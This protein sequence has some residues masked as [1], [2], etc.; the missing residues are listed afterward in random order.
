MPVLLQA[1]QPCHELPTAA[2]HANTLLPA[3]AVLL[4]AVPRLSPR[5]P[6]GPTHIFLATSVSL[7]CSFTIAAAA[8]PARLHAGARPGRGAQRG[9]RP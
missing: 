2:L 6:H 7:N 4:P 8:G 3:P 9:L 5:A 1:E